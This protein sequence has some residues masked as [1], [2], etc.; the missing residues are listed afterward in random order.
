MTVRALK[1]FPVLNE[2]EII[3][4]LVIQ[5]AGLR[6]A[7]LRQP[8]HAAGA[9]GF[10]LAINLL[11]QRPSHA[12]SPR[13]FADVKILEIAIAVVRPGGAMKQVMRNP[14]QA[15]VDIAAERK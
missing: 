8:V 9:G 7:G 2:P 15:A 4:D 6:V 14:A 3:R 5:G 10:R 13:V 1:N 12:P 11:D